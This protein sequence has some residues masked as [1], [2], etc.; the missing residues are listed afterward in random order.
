MTI[1]NHPDHIYNNS[2]VSVWL[3]FHDLFWTFLGPSRFWLIREQSKNGELLDNPTTTETLSGLRPQIFKCS[4]NYNRNVII[5]QIYAV[6]N[7]SS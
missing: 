7:L 5:C 1:E 2:H 4:F 6:A 3:A